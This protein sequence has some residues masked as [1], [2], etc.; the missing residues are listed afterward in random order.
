MLH[1]FY[2]AMKAPWF[3]IADDFTGSGDSAVQFRARGKPARLILGS[4][5]L[6]LMDRFRSAI[7][8]DSDSRYLSGTE[9]YAAVYRIARDFRRSGAGRI[10]KKID[11]T[12]RG[13][14]AEEVAAVMEGAQYSSVVVCPAAPRNGRS[15]VGGICLVDGAPIGSSPAGRDRFTPVAEAL[16]SAHFEE[17]FPG[18][19]RGLGLNSIR[20]GSG[21]LARELERGIADG[22]RVFIADAENLE[23]LKAIAELADRPGLL[24]AGS[25]GLAE[26]LAGLREAARSPIQRVPAERALF[27]VGS[28]TPTSALQCSRLESSGRVGSLVVDSERALADPEGELGRL[29]ALARRLPSGQAVLLKTDGLVPAIPEALLLERGT[30]V[31]R[32]LGR[33]ARDIAGRLGSR[34]IFASGGDTA[35]RIAEA[36]GVERIDFTDELLPGVPYG[37]CSSASLR[38]RLHFA[39]KSGGFGSPEALV[40][41]L[42][43]VA[44]RAG[45][46]AK[47]H[48]I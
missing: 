45:D 35:A 39:S 10:F 23:D 18:L 19:V 40:N 36:L 30:A 11:S 8:V 2:M 4:Y 28:L 17:R 33:A 38:R 44:L 47:E 16:V 3:I 15:V 46:M 21:K 24:L 26:A 41:I 7:V 25:S 32:F 31:S 27:I 9:A 13:N 43:L 1:A 22:G 48:K 14:I 20:S 37:G 34:F 6:K 42:E 29:S 5:R 12:L